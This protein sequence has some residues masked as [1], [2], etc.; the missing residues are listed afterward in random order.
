MVLLGHPDGGHGTGFVISRKHRLVAT[1]AHVADLMIQGRFR[2][3]AVADDTAVT[4]RVERVWYHPGILRWLGEGL[5]ARSDDPKD[6]EVTNSVPDLAVLQLYQGGP[7][8][9]A[10]FQ[11][12][13]DDELKNI[14]GQ[15]VGLLGYPAIL[16]YLWPTANQ[17]L[18]AAF[19][20]SKVDKTTSFFN[21]Q[22]APP[23]KRQGVW[24]EAE[25]FGPGSS[26]SPIFLGGGHVVGVLCTWKT[27]PSETAFGG[28]AF[29]ADCIRELLAYHKLADSSP[30]AV[31]RA[32][33]HPNWGPD[34]RL[35]PC[36]KAAGLVRD[37]DRLRRSGSFRQACEKC[38]EAL[39]LAPDYAGALLQRSKV[40]LYYVGTHWKSLTDAARHR[41]ADWAFDDSYRCVEIF[42]E[43]NQPWLF[44]SQNVI[45]YAASL[46]HD[47]S[48]FRDAIKSI[49]EMLSDDW[50]NNP[51]TD[52]ERGFAINL[53]AQC[54]HFLGEMEEA[55]RDYNKSILQAPDEPRWYLNRAQYWEQQG[56][57][58]LAERDR[59]T[60]Q[61]A[62]QAR[63]DS[64]K[65]PEK[66]AL[67]K[68]EEN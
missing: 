29:R 58:D 66:G 43:W 36:R 51:L 65:N 12:A 5:Y 20:I 54:H 38:N 6:G 24:C 60:A 50:S 33:S 4:Y 57:K 59:Q 53:R 31:E 49:D 19:T 45:Y 40:Y 11:L 52:S 2:M 7:D 9:P 18:S 13:E 30:E 8:L 22:R 64:E 35:G 32:R 42:P 63:I 27:S 37:A 3:Q 56:R 61:S 17:R 44:H 14:D 34:P 23:D 67:L 68:P 16:G 1:A 15:A 25:D 41:Y 47:A 62:R 26:G 55:E 39:E 28:S 21:D 46:P 10:E 48:T